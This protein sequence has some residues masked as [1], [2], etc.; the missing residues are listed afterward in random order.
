MQRDQVG[1]TGHAA[2]LTLSTEDV[3]FLSARPGG[4]GPLPSERVTGVLL[5]EDLAEP[6]SGPW[7]V[8]T[9]TAAAA[10]A[11]MS[12]E[13]SVSYCSGCCAAESRSSSQSGWSQ[14]CGKGSSTYILPHGCRQQGIW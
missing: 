13:P 3:A 11:A 9:L 6:P 14:G 5:T 4:F 7:G 8:L 1:C 2:S 12:S 10:A